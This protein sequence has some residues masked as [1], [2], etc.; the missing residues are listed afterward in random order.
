MTIDVN[1]FQPPQTLDKNPGQRVEFMNF[2][3][4]AIVFAMN[5]IA[6]AILGLGLSVQAGRT[7]ILL[8]SALLLCCGWVLCYLSPQLAKLLNIGSLIIAFTQLFPVLQIVIGSISLTI[9]R[10]LS[11]IPPPDGDDD[12]KFAYFY[13]PFTSEQDGFIVTFCVGAGLIACASVL[14]FLIGLFQRKSP[15]PIENNFSLG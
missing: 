10:R 2:V 14:G 11:G 3:H 12:A 9:T 15:D 1:P 6:P 4:W 7:G 5:M 8:A 13:G